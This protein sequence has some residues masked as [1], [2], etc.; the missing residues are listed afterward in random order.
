LVSAPASQRSAVTAPSSP[1]SPTYDPDNDTRDET[2]EDW[3]HHSPKPSPTDDTVPHL[4]PLTT[5]TD[6][7]VIPSNDESNN[8]RD[9]SESTTKQSNNL[10]AATEK[11]KLF[12]FGNAFC[13]FVRKR[14]RTRST[15][16]DE[17]VP[18]REDDI[19]ALTNPFIVQ[20]LEL[21]LRRSPDGSV[22]VFLD[23]AQKGDGTPNLV[24]QHA[25]KAM[26]SISHSQSILITDVTVRFCL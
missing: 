10:W 23:L 25:E 9:S 13:H 24:R 6:T 11:T 21:L 26:H 18:S 20:F 8:D 17:D 16:V 2:E 22:F 15:G 19:P 5:P 7:L 14:A 1:I 3:K 12:L 4:T